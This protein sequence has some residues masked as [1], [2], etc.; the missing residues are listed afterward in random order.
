MRYEISVVKPGEL[1][2]R[3]HPDDAVTEGQARFLFRTLAGVFPE[4]GGYTV[5]AY[6]VI[7]IEEIAEDITAEMRRRI[8]EDPYEVQPVE[9]GVI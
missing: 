4:S 6:Q 2:F 7:R 5:S 3:T 9:I 8:A 1:S